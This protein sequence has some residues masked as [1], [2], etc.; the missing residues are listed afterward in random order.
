M[1]KF[2]DFSGKKFGRL[3]VLDKFKKIGKYNF[4]LCKC[5]C[6]KLIWIR[7]NSFNNGHAT[8]CGCSRRKYFIEKTVYKTALHSVWNNMKGR[9][10]RKTDHNYRNYGNRGIEICDEWK[11][12]DNGF[13]NFYNWAIKNGYKKGLSIDR[14]DNNGN[15]SPENCRWADMKTQNN[16]QRSTVRIKYNGIEKTLEEW[17]KIVKIPKRT[18]YKRIKEQ[19][20][21]IE[22]AF[23][24][25][26]Q[27]KFNRYKYKFD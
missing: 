7:G 3:L 22:S 1:C 19:N 12:K 27:D 21:D 8:S 11:D 14:I 4:W 15:Y 13:K 6:G 18:I 16:N 26:V 2:V 25:P 10:Y 24:K 17:S 5:D 23:N 9:C 20:W